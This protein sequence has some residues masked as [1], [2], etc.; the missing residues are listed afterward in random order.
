[1]DMEK[2]NFGYSMKNIGL[3]S[4]REYL[5]QL[6]H[7]T[8]SFVCNLRWRSY[9]FL[10]PT[11]SEK[12]EEFEFQS[13]RATPQIKELQK[14]EDFLYELVNNIKFRKYRNDLQ[15]VLKKR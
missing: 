2:V 15:K 13:I 14:L 6:I 10:N 5:H 4:H 1:M 8:E 3:P 12:N 7:S 11:T 9:F